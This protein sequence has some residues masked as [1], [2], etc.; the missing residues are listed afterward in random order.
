M[1]DL[2]TL[3]NLAEVIGGVTVVGGVAFGLLQLREFRLQRSASAAIELIQS[4]QGPAWSAAI[5]RVQQL[6]DRVSAA[7]LRQRGADFEDAALMVGVTFET[8]GLVTFRRVVPFSIVQDLVGGL[9]VV[10]WRKL[11][12]WTEEV[13][14]EQGQV[15]WLEWFQWLAERLEE[16]GTARGGAPAYRAFTGWRPRG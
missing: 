13:R 15:T 4:I 16:H 9:T 8:I 10:M 2:Q 12:A 6:P 7:E 1:P 5:G 11:S 3:A 14:K